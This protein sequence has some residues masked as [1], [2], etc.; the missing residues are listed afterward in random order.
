ML[1]LILKLK[2]DNNEIIVCFFSMRYRKFRQEQ[3][4]PVMNRKPL[5]L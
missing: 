5:P 1:G 4:L 2:D 3:G